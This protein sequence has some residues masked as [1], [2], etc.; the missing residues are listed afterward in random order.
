MR[1]AGSGGRAA[2]RRARTTRLSSRCLAISSVH[3]WRS[4]STRRS[5]ASRKVAARA[6]LSSS[7]AASAPA[8]T[9]RRSRSEISSTSLAAASARSRHSAAL[10]R[11]SNDFGHGD[12]LIG[13]GR[14]PALGHRLFP[15]E[16][17]GGANGRDPAPQHLLGDRLLL[18]RQRGHHRLPVGPARVEAP[19]PTLGGRRPVRAAP[20]PPPATGWSPCGRRSRPVRPG[21]ASD[22]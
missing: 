19:R 2:R 3:C 18:G 5:S 20:A 16:M 12:Q 4:P 11:G 1:A 8:T 22:R 14:G 15:L 7:R 17:E 21:P 13:V 9:D 10:R 6:R